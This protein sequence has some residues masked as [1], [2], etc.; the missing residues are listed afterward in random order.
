MR[1]FSM[2]KFMRGWPSRVVPFLLA[3]WL[4]LCAAATGPAQRTTYI[5]AVTPQISASAIHAEWSPFLA[6]LGH[7]TGIQLQLRAHDSKQAFDLDVAGGIPDLVYL[8]PQAVAGARQTHGYLPLVRDSTLLTGILLVTQESPIRTLRDLHGHTLI[9]PWETAF[10]SSVYIRALLHEQE[11]IDFKTVYAGNHQNVYR[12]LLLGEATAGASV[13]NVLAKESAAMRARLRILYTTPGMAPHAFA[14][15]P[16]VPSVQR[17]QLIQA[18]FKLGQ[19]A[20]GNALLNAINIPAPVVAD[21]QRDYAWTEKFL[22][23][24]QKQTGKKP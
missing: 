23:S 15:H 11:K 7:A 16:R 20:E 2:Q 6:A 19:N 12:Q 17:E 3:I 10:A 18:I 14:A 5:V 8:N 13:P 22:L 9:F 21:Y 4:P 24:K 1:Q